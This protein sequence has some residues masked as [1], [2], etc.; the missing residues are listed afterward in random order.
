MLPNHGLVLGTGLLKDTCHRFWFLLFMPFTYGLRKRQMKSN[1]AC[2]TLPVSSSACPNSTVSF[3]HYIAF[4]TYNNTSPIQMT[5]STIGMAIQ[6]PPPFWP[7]F[8]LLLNDENKS[9]KRRNRV[10]AWEEESSSFNG[11]KRLLYHH[12]FFLINQVLRK[13]CCISITAHNQVGGASVACTF[14]GEVFSA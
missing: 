11:G 13:C 7:S 10:D 8:L 9:W 4:I 2:I 3:I 14:H 5:S 12:S 6:N 1:Y